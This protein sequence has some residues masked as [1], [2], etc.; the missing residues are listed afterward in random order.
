M[1][2]SY[3]TVSAL[4]KYIQLLD[5]RQARIPARPC[6]ARLPELVRSNCCQS[7]DGLLLGLMRPVPLQRLNCKLEVIGNNSTG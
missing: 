3:G 5:A 6:R 2:P 1:I 4:V 7:E